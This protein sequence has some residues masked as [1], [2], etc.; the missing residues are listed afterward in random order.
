MLQGLLFVC[1]PAVLPSAQPCERRAV[2]G[3]KCADDSRRGGYSKGK[4]RGPGR[5]P[6]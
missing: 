3:R 4:E 5:L 1:A 6:F 2:K